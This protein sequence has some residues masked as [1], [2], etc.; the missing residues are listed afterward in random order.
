MIF[1][2][3]TRG[4]LFVVSLFCGVTAVEGQPAPV[5]SET[6][7]F[8]SGQDGYHTYRIPAIVRATNGVLLAFCEGRKNSS[9]DSGNI[10]IVLRRSADNGAT[11]SVMTLVQEEG[12]NATITIGN[13]AP[14]VDETTGFIHLLFCRN[15]DRVFHTVSTDNG[16]TWSARTEITGA[17]KLSD[18]GWYATG[19]GHGVQLKRGNQAGRLVVASDHGTTNGVRGA[20]VVFSDDHGATWQLGGVNPAFG[21]VN[22]N[23][24]LCEELV[25]TAPGGGSRVYFNTRDQNGSA[26]GTRGQAWSIDSGSSFAGPFT[27]RAAFVCP[28]VQGSVVRLR[29]TDQGSPINKLLFACPNHASS[30]SNMAVWASTDEGVTWGEPRPVYTGPSAYSDLVRVA[31]DEIGLLYEKGATSAYETITFARFN[32]AWLEDQPPV[33]EKENPKAAFWNVEEKLPGQTAGTNKGAILDVH[34]EAFANHLTAEQ[35][36]AYIAGSTN[37]GGGSALA[38]DGSGG[39]QL[40]DAATGDHFDFG[41]SNSFTIEAVFRIPSGST[42]TGALVAK[43]YG[44]LLPSWWFRVEAGKLRFLVSDG[45]VEKAV[46]AS[47]LVND[48]QWHHA[49]AVR[50]ARVPGSKALRL[51]LDGVLLTNI[52]DTTTQ[53]LANAQPLNIGRF[54]AA[55]TRNL[56]GDIDLVRI[57]PEAL[58]ATGFAG[59]YTQFDADEDAIPDWFERANYSSLAI[60]GSGDTDAD[61]VRDV[62]EFALGSDA[63]EGGSRPSVV[64]LPAA[65]S[66]GVSTLQRELPEWLTMGLEKSSNLVDWVQTS[67][68]LEVTPLGGG[69]WRRTQTVPYPGGAPEK[70]F[71][72]FR[73]EGISNKNN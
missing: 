35:P 43:D 12:N 52:T 65:T 62:A 53:S 32:E 25:A 29:A 55:A 59:R 5:F 38:F 66:V 69:L 54:G 48:G 9:S 17:V 16:A 23:E 34:P 24:T 28:V 72:R 50:D 21:G 57:T 42:Q 60:L 40:A 18:W 49:A 26:P 44:S 13:P 30:R 33:T 14:V 46:T 8:V 27:N 20:Q 6:V 3:C 37:F 10:D 39:L 70:L 71:L 36:F 7:P 73:V 1:R 68:L 31:D 15:N 2:R 58:D 56:T 4:L 11:W 67:S 47:T 51:F 22:P 19:P 63:L 61:G 64:A 45:V 41:P